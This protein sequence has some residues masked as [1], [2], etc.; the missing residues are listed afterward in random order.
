MQR[1]H[2]I[3][4]PGDSTRRGGW[5]DYLLLT[6]PRVISLLLLTTLAAM[7]LATRDQLPSLPTMLWTV[8]GGYLAAGGANAIN[9]YLD[10][11]LDG[12]MSRT[13]HRPLPMQRL[14]PRHALRFGAALALLA[15]MVLWHG[16]N[17]LAALLALGGL[18][19]YVFVY[20]WWLKRRT[21]H[22]VTIGGVAGA[23]PPLVGWAA[24]T[25]TL[26]PLAFL[27]PAI[28]L[29]WTPAHFWALA[30]M[31][32][33]EYARARVPM[34]PV[35][36]GETATRIAILAYSTLTVTLTLV[37]LLL[38]LTR[39]LFLATICLLDALLLLYAIELCRTPDMRTTRRYYFYA[40]FYLAAL[41]AALALGQ[42]LA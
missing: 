1:I 15:F 7:C 22:N 20:S 24:A 8:F 31:R 41:V 19:H 33:E 13:C 38:G 26:T 36:R 35:V 39:G 4:R 14:E 16:A 18:V 23:I 27:L 30:L 5:L 28:I 6:K 9:C 11:D 12:L 37:P 42:V 32:R 21:R 17:L 2:R 10:R 34:L 40:L 25:G 29:C 3:A